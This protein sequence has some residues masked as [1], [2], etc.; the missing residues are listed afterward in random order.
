MTDRLIVSPAALEAKAT[1]V[2]TEREK[3]SNILSTASAE[4]QS[5][6]ATWQSTAADAYRLQFD[7]Q[8][9]ELENI[10]VLLDNQV[11]GLLGAAGIFDAGEKSVTAKNEALP[12]VN[13]NR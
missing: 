1:E 6:S 9:I 13:I 8:R 12:V 10:L 5:L 11:R 7:K 4:I 3:I 2:K